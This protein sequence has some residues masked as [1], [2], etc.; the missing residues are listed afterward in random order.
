MTPQVYIVVLNYR[1]A[2]D[3]I[4]CLESV[5]RL[6][7]ARFRIVLVDNA[8]PDDSVVQL[9]AWLTGKQPYVPVPNALAGFTTPPFPKPIRFRELTSS[10]AFEACPEPFIFIRN[11]ANTG[12]AGGNN[13]GIRFVLAQG[14]ADYIWLL[15]NDTVV[16][17]D[18]L[19]FLVATLDAAANRGEKVGMCGSQLLYYDCPDLIQGLGGKFNYWLCTGNNIG[20][21]QPVQS[22]VMPSQ[23]DYVIGASCLVSI[24]FLRDVGLLNE[25]YFL[26]YEE[27]DW[28]VRGRKR[29]WQHTH[30]Y[31]SVI[32]HKESASMDKTSP[33][34]SA[35]YDYHG[36]RSRLLFTKKHYPQYLPLVVSS[37][38]GVGI[39]RWRRGQKD[40]IRLVLR[41]LKETLI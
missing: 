15:N 19:A 21:G 30:N 36:F 29:G 11:E 40:R 26:F 10:Q 31:S 33:G 27:I 24:A 28:A 41:A 32:Y 16:T 37:F 1:H 2:A 4:E 23:S 34:R 13:V 18:A 12:F 17:P 38:I 8:S 22:T 7:Y 25:T 14:D 5:Q 20:I 35:M 39:N 6:H 9:R 3:T